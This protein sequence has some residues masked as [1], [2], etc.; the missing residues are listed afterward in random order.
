MKPAKT[1]LR[2]NRKENKTD[3]SGQQQQQKGKQYW[4]IRTTKRKTKLTNQDNNSNKKENKTD[5][6]GQQQQ[7][8]KQNWPIRITTNKQKGKNTNQSGQQQKGT[9]NWPIRATTKSKAINQ[10]QQ[11]ARL[12]NDQLSKETTFITTGKNIRHHRETT[13]VTEYNMNHC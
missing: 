4:P 12:Q 3:H 10:Q 6:S 5:Q 9:Q 2:N 1:T 13:S 7:K 8:G 11:W